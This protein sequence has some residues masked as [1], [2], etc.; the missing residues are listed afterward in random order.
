MPKRRV[1]SSTLYRVFEDRPALIEQILV[2]RMF[3]MGS[4]VRKRLSRLSNFEEALVEGSMVSIA[5]G[6]RDKLFN[7]IV[8]KA[9]NHR[10]EQLLLRRSLVVPTYGIRRLKINELRAFW[11]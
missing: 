2:E 5:A 10:I 4:N 3:T 6:R 1:L 8:Q 9:T 11:G 7:E